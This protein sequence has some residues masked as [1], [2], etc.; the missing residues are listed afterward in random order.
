MRGKRDQVQRI[1]VLLSARPG[2]I[3]R[4]VEKLKDEDAKLRKN[5][6]Q[7]MISSLPVR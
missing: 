1:S 6:W 2:E 5:L 7:L 3:A 4:A